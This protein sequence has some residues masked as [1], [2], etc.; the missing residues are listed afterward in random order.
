VDIGAQ[1]AETEAALR[2]LVQ[3]HKSEVAGLGEN[4]SQLD[5]MTDAYS[6]A[7]EG[8]LE[9]LAT[10]GNADA[11]YRLSDMAIRESDKPADIERWFALT[12]CAADLGHPLALSELVRW[13]WHQRGDGSID[14]VQANRATAFAYADRAA[15]AGNMFGV[16]RI[17]T[18]VAG[19]VHQYPA[20]LGLAQ[21]L[22]RLCADTGDKQCGAEMAG[23]WAYDPGLSPVDAAAWVAI[24]AKDQPERFGGRRAKA[25]ATLTDKERDLAAALASAWR[26]TPWLSLRM[27]WRLV[28]ADI[29]AYGQSSIGPTPACDT[30]RP[31]CR[32]VKRVPTMAQDRGG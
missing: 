1:R 20:N 32:R 9:P 4:S 5:A 23:E 22:L 10:L 21:R 24:M 15:L 25:W 3:Q 16:N 2:Q 12:A 18:Y 19:N 11:M 26:P 29:L 28:Q 31:W 13:Y 14:E 27:R 6:R 30:A 17:A 7:Y 8:I